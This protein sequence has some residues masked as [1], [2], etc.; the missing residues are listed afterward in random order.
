[1]GQTLKCHQKRYVNKPKSVSK[2]KHSK[3]TDH[4]SGSLLVNCNRVNINLASEEELMTLP[5]ISR[6]MAHSITVYRRQL[7]GFRKVEDL[8]LVTG[9]GAEKMQQL[10][11]E[12]CVGA[13]QAS[14]L[15]SSISTCDLHSRKKVNVNTAT[16]EQLLQ[17]G[18]ISEELAVAILLYRS[19]HGAFRQLEDLQNV[20]GVDSVV[21]KHI[22][23]FITV[24]M[25][26]PATVYAD[27]K[28]ESSGTEV[29]P[30]TLQ[31][32][33]VGIL[34]STPESTLSVKSLAQPFSGSYVGR[35]VIR[36]GNWD[37]QG[38]TLEKAENPEVR[39][40]ICLTLL[41]NGISLLAVQQVLEE[42]ALEKI[43]KEIETPSLLALK[44]W[45]G[46]R[47]RWRY[48]IP[49]CDDEAQE[50]ERAAFMWDTTS[51]LE[52][53]N[54]F[55]LE[56]ELLERGQQRH[57]KPL[58]GHFKVDKLNFKLLNIYL[59]PAS[60][61]ED[62]S[63]SPTVHLQSLK[64]YLEGHWG[65]IWDRLGSPKIL[66]CSLVNGVLFQHCPLWVEF[67]RQ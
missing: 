64:P 55:T 52:L 39:G 48:I 35:N 62:V 53:V 23:P 49:E 16:Q 46:L 54:T 41:E 1:M 61:T 21:L 65:I 60:K 47:G 56:T 19:H 37:F 3:Y 32:S 24:E 26:R 7:G 58:F 27:L 42:L 31:N 50:V 8:S 59:K 66:D 28:W 43:C 67:Y 20:N 10:R 5:G 36:F 40:M 51:G 15:R 44:D 30:Q 9:F 12:I 33:V 63:C 22:E 45:P 18:G 14:P 2:K 29:I 4:V 11:P 34:S 57:R 25:P 13:V 6:A 17:T 38:L